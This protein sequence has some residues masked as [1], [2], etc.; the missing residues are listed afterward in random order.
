MRKE[1]PEYTCDLGYHRQRQ[2]KRA[3]RYRLARRTAEVQRAVER[4]GARAVDSVLDVGT[5]DGLMLQRLHRQWPQA[6]FVGVDLS[7]EL[8]LVA[9]EAC[10]SFVCA[11]ALD[12]PFAADAFGLVISTATIEHLSDPPK[13]VAE[14]H[15]VL[16][17]D[18][19]CVITTPVPVFERIATRIG[20][21]PREGHHE[22]LDL[23][24]LGRLFTEA[25]FA[26][27]EASRFMISPWGF[28]GEQTIER[29]MHSI[30]LH[31]LLLNQIMVARKP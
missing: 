16:R 31:F 26:I 11:N 14:C 22:T 24:R 23:Q 8:L 5:A 13:M 10:A 2:T 9:P 30:G 17:P 6:H 27:Q 3:L 15:R 18:G 4:Y 21:L 25:G 1:L 12:L 7:R 20:H 29:I 19:L 28:P